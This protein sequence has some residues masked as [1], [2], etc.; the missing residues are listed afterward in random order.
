MEEAIK[1]VL[2]LL[3]QGKITAEEAERL[4]RAIKEAE[5]TKEQTE[6]ESEKGAKAGLGI[7]SEVLDEVFTTV[8]ETVRTSIGSALEIAL[9]HE[10]FEMET[11]EN[12][13]KLNVKVLGGDLKI[14]PA[15]DEKITASFKG[16]YRV[17]ED[18]LNITIV[19]DAKIKVPQSVKIA[20]TLLGGDVV[21]KGYYPEINIDVKGGDFGGKIDFERL[22]CRVTG[23]DVEVITPKKPLKLRISALGG[24]YELPSELKKSENYYVFG[25]GNYREAEIKIVGGN[26]VLKFKEE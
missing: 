16:Q 4:I 14:E 25:D 21:I 15:E 6:K 26:F 1:K 20:L 11:F 23:G 7:I 22:T 8:G 2:D 10:K 24:D 12:V 5:L 18:L 19:D 13:K 17:E 3:E 9:K